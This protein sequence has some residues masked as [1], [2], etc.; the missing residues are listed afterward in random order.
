MERSRA[1]FQYDGIPYTIHIY[2]KYGEPMFDT[3]QIF[4]I[5]DMTEQQ[6][7]TIALSSDHVNMVKGR[8]VL[9]QLGLYETLCFCNTSLAAQLK[10]WFGYLILEIYMQK[11]NGTMQQNGKDTTVHNTAKASRN[12]LMIAPDAL[13][14][15]L[16]L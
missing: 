12:E 13:E 16:A 9:N 2:Y 7:E 10:K 6:M 1:L 4:S 14:M 15:I 3:Q 5:L 11:K 8:I